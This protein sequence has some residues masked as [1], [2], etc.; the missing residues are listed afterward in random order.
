MLHVANECGF[1]GTQTMRR[2]DLVN[3]LPFVQNTRIDV[4]EK[5][6]NARLASLF[7]QLLLDG[8][9]QHEHSASAF[10]AEVKEVFC[11]GNDGC[12]LGRSA[13]GGTKY[14]IQ[15]LKRHARQHPLIEYRERQAEL[16]FESLAIHR[17]FPKAGQHDIGCIDHW[18]QV[19]H[20][21]P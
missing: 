13:E 14:R 10:F 11:V 17:R 1:L 9:A 19:V 18:R 6:V 20:Q 3:L 7:P 15:F 2:Q 21:R 16:A 12:R 5:I 8:G 4:L